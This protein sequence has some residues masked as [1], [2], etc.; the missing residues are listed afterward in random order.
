LLKQIPPDQL[1]LG[2]YIQG[3]EGSWMD[4]PFWRS[5]FVLE[6]PKD[7]ERVLASGVPVSG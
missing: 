7:L 4:H 6:D 5:R 1:R 3:F 2:M